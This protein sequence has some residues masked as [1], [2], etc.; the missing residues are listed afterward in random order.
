M[1]I[2]IKTPDGWKPVA[3]QIKVGGQY[4]ATEGAVKK[5]GIWISSRVD[6]PDHSGCSL[7]L[8]VD[9][10]PNHGTMV[11]AQLTGGVAGHSRFE[12]V[13]KDG[14]VQFFVDLRPTNNPI[15]FNE[16]T[17]FIRLR[18]VVQ[19][20]P[21]TGAGV[22]NFDTNQIITKVVLI[23]DNLFGLGKYPRLNATNLTGVPANLPPSIRGLDYTFS[24]ASATFNDPNVSEWDVSKVVNFTRM[25]QAAPTFNQPLNKWN[26]GAA[27]DMSYMF[28]GAAKFNQDISMWDVTKVSSFKGFRLQCPLETAHTP[29]KFR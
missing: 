6:G 16:Y 9:V 19:G 28:Y 14:V 21:L 24:N 7:V 12:C 13:D 23:D 15:P 18:P 3:S 26:T 17:K 25:F 10:Q 1:S 27:T 20:S 29:I 11:N 2:E 5:N 22:I 4:K 8:V